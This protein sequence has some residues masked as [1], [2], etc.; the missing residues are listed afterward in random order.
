MFPVAVI[1]LVYDSRG[2]V[3]LL[4]Q[5]YIHTQYRNLVSG[6]LLPGETA[7]KCAVRE[8]A[9]ETGQQVI[10]LTPA[11]TWWFS[12]KEMLMIG[13]FAQ[14]E[15]NMPLELSSEVDGAEWVPAEEAVKL[16]HPAGSTSHALCTRFLHY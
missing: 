7:E 14:V 5:N 6:Y 12:K 3:L 10:N 15:D 2:R 4:R 16:V 9:E 11:G 1:A 8:I 13:F